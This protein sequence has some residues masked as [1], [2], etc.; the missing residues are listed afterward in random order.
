MRPELTELPEPESKADLKL[1]CP[2]SHSPVH[3]SL[4]AGRQ[5]TYYAGRVTKCC[6]S[7]CFKFN[8]ELLAEGKIFELNQQLLDRE[9]EA[10]KE[11]RKCPASKRTRGGLGEGLGEG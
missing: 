8:P 5:A 9:R 11:A 1:P 10:R 7:A 2:C 6:G 4:C 3:A